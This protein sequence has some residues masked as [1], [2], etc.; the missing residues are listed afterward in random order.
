MSRLKTP[1][2]H[3]HGYQMETLR[4]SEYLPAPNTPTYCPRS[5]SVPLGL[6]LARAGRYETAAQQKDIHFP[7][8]GSQ[9]RLHLTDVIELLVREFGAVT[10]DGWCESLSA[11]RNRYYDAEKD[12]VI[13]DNLSRAV[14]LLE[15][16]GYN[17][18]VAALTRVDRGPCVSKA[19]T[20]KA[21]PCNSCH[22]AVV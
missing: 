19:T 18:A 16:A 6:L 13:H 5:H 20:H 2:P 12:R 15:D 10:E 9:F 17:A 3:Q 14:F 11:H 1:Q 22:N 8:G 7:M 21:Q 4:A